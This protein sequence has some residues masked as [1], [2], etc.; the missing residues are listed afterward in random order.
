MVLPPFPAAKLAGCVPQM[1]S[2][3]EDDRIPVRELGRFFRW[4]PYLQG[5]L[6][7]GSWGKWERGG[8]QY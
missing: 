3:N 5:I 1:C 2:K 7:V 8:H 6:T 4:K